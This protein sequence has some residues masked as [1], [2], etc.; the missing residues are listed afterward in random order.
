MRYI[1]IRKKWYTDRTIEK[2]VSRAEKMRSFGVS[3]F[4]IEI[5]HFSK[6]MTY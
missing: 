4:L 1:K 2:D 5:S 6:K 3:F